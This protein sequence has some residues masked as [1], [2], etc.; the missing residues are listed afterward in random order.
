MS[1]PWKTKKSRVKNIFIQKVNSS[2][3][4]E[5]K[6]KVAQ[7]QKK[8]K[9]G[10]PLK[11]FQSVY[12]DL[13]AI[14]KG[15]GEWCW[16][17]FLVTVNDGALLLFLLL[18]LLLLRPSL[19]PSP[20]VLGAEQF[21]L[22]AAAGREAAGQS[23]CLSVT[24]CVCPSALVSSV[25]VHRGRDVGHYRGASSCCKVTCY[26]W[27]CTGREWRGRWDPALIMS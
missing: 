15:R 13:S 7:E 1:F 18:L 22:W 3:S 10:H 12:E 2:V 19:S 25:V 23:G 5:D 27:T 6:R 11:Q 8:N 21:P 9:C 4:L 24:V 26:S 14:C 16:R 20:R 17:R